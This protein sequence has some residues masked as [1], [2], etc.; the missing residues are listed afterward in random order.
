[1]ALTKQELNSLLEQNK[2]KMYAT[3]RD[4]V[5][6]L[7]LERKQMLE[8]LQTSVYFFT[9]KLFVAFISFLLTD[10][11]SYNS[12]TLK[13]N[14]SYTTVYCPSP[15]FENFYAVRQ[16]L[17]SLDTSDC[18]WGL[19]EVGPV[20]KTLTQWIGHQYSALSH[21]IMLNYRPEFF[22]ADPRLWQVSC[23][24]MRTARLRFGARSTRPRLLHSLR[25]ITTG[26]TKTAASTAS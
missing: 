6:S 9:P 26:N 11:P 24:I 25:S 14:M 5:L 17:I 1:M 18:F 12:A 10:Q 7:S 8:E 22:T 21:T 4:G 16:Y 3:S 2:L 13:Q 15:E 20:K 23:L 19:T